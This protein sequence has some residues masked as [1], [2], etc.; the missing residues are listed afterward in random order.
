MVFL[1]SSRNG[2]P[3]GFAPIPSSG[4]LPCEGHQRRRYSLRV[5]FQFSLHLWVLWIE[6]FY[7]G[8]SA[9]PATN[10][11]NKVTQLQEDVRRHSWHK[12][13]MAVGSQG[14]PPPFEAHTIFKVFGIG[15][16]SCCQLSSFLTGYYGILGT[17]CTC[18]NSLFLQFSPNH[19]CQQQKY[20]RNPDLSLHQASVGRQHISLNFSPA[21]LLTS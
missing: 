12:I 15:K 19:Q 5:G 1:P 20:I 9:N 3:E 16:Q 10:L 2:G 21:L 18:W 11:L 14:A 7:G 6:G 17:A 8:R 13:W 4:K